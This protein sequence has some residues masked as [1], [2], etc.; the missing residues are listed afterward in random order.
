MKNIFGGTKM[1]IAEVSK[2]YDITP[3][4]LRYYE[5][6]GLIPKVE[7]TAGGIRNYTEK[8]CIWI[9]FMKCMRGAGVSVNTMIEY[10][11]LFQ[12]GEDTKDARKQLLIRERD[13]IAKQ[14][15][16]LSETLEFLDKKLERYDSI[17]VPAEE[18]LRLSKLYGT[19]EN[20]SKVSENEVPYN[21]SVL[22]M[23]KDVE[24]YDISRNV[25]LSENLMPGCILRGTMQYSEWMKT[26]YSAGSNVSARR[27]MLKAFGSDNHESAIEATRTL[28]LSD[29]YWL[30]KQNEKVS[31]NE[32]TP[33]LHTEWDGTGVFKGGSI[34]TLFVN[35]AADKQWLDSKTLLKV[36][37]YKE[38]EPYLLCTAL[39]LKNVTEAK[40]TDDGILLTNFTSTNQFLESM[41]QSGFSRELD[42]PREK[43]VDIFKE[44]AVALFVVDYLVEHDDRH[45]GNY[46]FLRDSNT[47]EYLSMAPYYDFDWA[48]SGAVV[49]LPENAFSNHSGFIRS[50]CEKAISIS[51]EFE[52]SEVIIK[53][54]HE[55]VK[56]T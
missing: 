21:K 3:D 26:R 35:G 33:Y 37:S 31:F 32:V 1:T 10:V 46:G 9:N 8:D 50:L 20:G 34:S 39:E 54:A 7:R 28:S 12:Q 41:E 5:K 24:V 25:V 56:T 15:A 55:L 13:K 52:H 42:N 47:G 49:P 22:L 43:A 40:I 51:D 18:N 44:Q 17:I 19:T 4:T 48:W 6:I 38:Y 45:W 16:A 30:K 14:V 27:L 36:K 11:T 29:C 23:C 2:K 53:R